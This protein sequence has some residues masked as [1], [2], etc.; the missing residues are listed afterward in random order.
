MDKL[1]HMDD[2]LLRRCKALI[3]ERCCNYDHG[4]CL[5]LDDGESCPC[6]QSISHSLLCKWFRLAVLPT[7]P[8]LEA[9]VLHTEDER[10]CAVCFKPIFAASNAT[11]YCPDCAILVRRKQD[12]KRQ[13]KRYHTLRK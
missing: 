9:K 12:A 13:R 10:R 11:K 6:V 2:K 3:R 1:P 4:C 5:A 7:D 8:E